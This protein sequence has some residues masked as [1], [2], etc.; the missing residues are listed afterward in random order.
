MTKFLFTLL[1]AFGMCS[2]HAQSAAPTVIS[3]SG[4]SGETAG[5]KV[6]WTLG[7]LAVTTLSGTSNTLTQGFHQP[8][9]I[10]VS[11]ED[12]RPDISM[13][14]FPNPTHQRVILSHSSDLEL[15]YQ[16]FDSRGAAIHQNDCPAGDNEIALDN[17]APGH[18]HLS[19]FHKGQLLKTFTIE[20]TGL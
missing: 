3:S 4:G 19:I 5:N 16:L 2:L 14:L 1:C 18:Y 9:L 6:D 10:I 15:N 17:M 7:E 8:Q 20:K 13:K 12:E 11:N